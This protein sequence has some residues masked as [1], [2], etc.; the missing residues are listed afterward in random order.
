MSDQ[1]RSTNLSGAGTPRLS[2]LVD[3]AMQHFECGPLTP[4]TPVG[5]DGTA[6]TPQGDAT[7]RDWLEGE[8]P[9]LT[10]LT[11]RE[12]AAAFRDAFQ[13]GLA[14]SGHATDGSTASPIA[15]GVILGRLPQLDTPM[16]VAFAR[17]Q[18]PLPAELQFGAL[19]NPSTRH[20]ALSQAL[21]TRAGAETLTRAS[22]E[23][24]GVREQLVEFQQDRE[25][26]VI[27]L[28]HAAAN[29]ASASEIADV[30]GGL[31]V[32]E[33]ARNDAAA[34][35]VTLRQDMQKH[36]RFMAG[37]DVGLGVVVDRVAGAL[38]QALQRVDVLQGELAGLRGKEHEVMLSGRFGAV[39]DRVLSEGALAEA[40]PLID[41]T[42]RELR[43]G[44][45]IEDSMLSVLTSQSLDVADRVTDS[46][47]QLGL[48]SIAMRTLMDFGRVRRAGSYE[49]LGLAEPRYQD[50][51]IRDML[52]DRTVDAV[53]VAWPSAGI[54]LGVAVAPLEVR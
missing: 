52:L 40:R 2:T 37:E 27:F 28:G 42:T 34:A 12:R 9:K 23:L 20:I 49:T 45:M 1:A 54:A 38:P 7:A 29:H 18:E 51:V 19:G 22:T 15:V 35:L 46:G 31:G 17:G 13:A 43:N 33:G 25:S 16:L 11:K 41:W 36:A 5:A 44:T 4:R 48:G 24:S 39:R 53:G 6:Q 21:L 32:A 26:L 47:G 50:A 14:A 30:L 10:A 3:E 8:A